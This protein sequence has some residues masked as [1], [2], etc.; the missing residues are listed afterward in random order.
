MI[1][2]SIEFSKYFASVPNESIKVIHEVVTRYDES[3]SY[4]TTRYLQVIGMQLTGRKK[5]WSEERDFYIPNASLNVLK[6]NF[7]S[8]YERSK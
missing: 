3:M 6:T 8:S 7:L 5:I 1:V 4:N 2:Y